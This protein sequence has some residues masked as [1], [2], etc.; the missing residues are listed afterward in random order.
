M[1]I[2]VWMDS[3][4][5]CQSCKTDIFDLEE[6]LGITPEEWGNMPDDEKDKIM[7]E[8]AFEGTDWGY[9]IV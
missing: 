4:A 8:V 7:R 5:N 9:E 1:K 2:K 6:D 3:G